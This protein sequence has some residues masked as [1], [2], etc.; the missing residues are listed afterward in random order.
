MVLHNS[1]TVIC[2]KEKFSAV[3]I[4]NYLYCTY[5]LP[6]YVLY[7]YDKILYSNFVPD[8]VPNESPLGGLRWG[9]TSLAMPQ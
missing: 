1:F 2:T 4:G 9:H 8:I 6:S 7:Q 5:V 3:T